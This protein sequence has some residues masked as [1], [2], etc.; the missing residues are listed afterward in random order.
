MRVPGPRQTSSH[1]ASPI[2]E[3]NAC[4]QSGETKAPTVSGERPGD[5]RAGRPTARRH[6]NDLY[7]SSAALE[8]VT[9]F[10]GKPGGVTKLLHSGIYYTRVA[11]AAKTSSPLFFSLPDF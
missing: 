10:P 4:A 1:R 7:F 2:A 8:G 11:L 6:R 5:L 3:M 9:F